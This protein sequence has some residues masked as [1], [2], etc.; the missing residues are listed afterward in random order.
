MLLLLKST[1]SL[2]R[3]QRVTK[4]RRKAWHPCFHFVSILLW[5]IPSCCHLSVTLEFRKDRT[6]EINI[7][8][9]EVSCLLPGSNDLF[10]MTRPWLTN[11]EII[12]NPDQAFGHWITLCLGLFNYAHLLPPAPVLPPCKPKAP[13]SE[14]GL[15]C[16]S[17]GVPGPHN[18]SPLYPSQLRASLFGILGQVARPDTWNALE[19]GSGWQLWIPF[20]CICVWHV[21]WGHVWNF[22]LWHRVGTQEFQTLE[23]FRF[24]FF[25]SDFWFFSF[26]F[27]I[28]VF[29][30][31]NSNL[32]PFSD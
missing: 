19:L 10:H 13:V 25:F 30:R 11:P 3:L 28:F 9:Q 24:P 4:N 27:T 26:R 20:Q 31:F 12:V 21:H 15:K 1:D 22:L 29:K 5:V 16:F 2:L 8:W 14:D 18:K 6:E 7:L 32:I 17:H 23:Y